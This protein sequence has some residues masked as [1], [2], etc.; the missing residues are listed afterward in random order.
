MT[1][2]TFLASYGYLALLIGTFLEGETILVLGG[3]AAHQGYLKLTGVILSAFAGSLM[4]DQLFFFLGRRHK[5]YIL[6]KRPGWQSKIDRVNRLVERYENITILAFRFLYGLRSVT[7]FVLGMSGVRT[8]KFIILNC[9]GA[10]LW[11]VAVA[12]AGY[13]FGSAVEIFL[14]EIKHYEKFVLAGVASLG[15]VVWLYHLWRQRRRMSPLAN[16]V[17][18]S[19]EIRSGEPGQRPRQSTDK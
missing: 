2:G 19:Q 16:K 18:S 4:G 3:V 13:L 5:D 15:A 11:A 10:L 1:L 7:P 12:V 14:G 8:A 17:S 9:C 6:R